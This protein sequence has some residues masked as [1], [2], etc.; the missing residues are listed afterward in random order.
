MSKETIQINRKLPYKIEKK[1]KTEISLCVQI[2]SLFCSDTPVL[3]TSLLRPISGQL[4]SGPHRLLLN[5]LSTIPRVDYRPKP[6]LY[7]ILKKGR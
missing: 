4:L 1:V 3:Y 2:L 6:N 5:E 7:L